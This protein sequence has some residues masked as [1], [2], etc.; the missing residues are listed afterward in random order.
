M[1]QSQTALQKL[2]HERMLDVANSAA[3]TMDGDYFR[4]YDGTDTESEKYKETLNN[5]HVFSDNM[6]LNYIYSIRMN[7][8]GRFVFVIDPDPVKPGLYGE[9][10]VQTE[11]QMQA[12]T[13]KT[14]TVDQEAFLDRWGK[15]YSAYS[16]VFDGEGN[17][18]ALIAVDFDA[19]W[20]DRQLRN[21]L[22]AILIGS[23]FSLFIG[24]I[25]SVLVTTNIR[26]R[27]RTVDGELNEVTD[28]LTELSTEIGVVAEDEL[29]KEE[30][31]AEPTG[32]KL[33]NYD[34]ELYRLGEKLDF[35]HSSIRTYITQT[36][37]MAYV[38][39]M[40]KVAN[41]TAYLE[42]ARKI[43]QDVSCGNADFMIA[44]TDINGL[45]NVNDNYGHAY[46]DRIITD[47]A[48]LLREIFGEGQ[49]FR[50]GG[51]EFISVM[52]FSD[53]ALM[54][55]AFFALDE[56]IE[57]FNKNERNYEP[58]LS[59]AKGYAVF[60]PESDTS[61]RAVFKRA[62]DAMYEDKARYYMSHGD[63]RRRR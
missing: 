53:E 8:N 25:F 62:D 60:D 56:R 10:I 19:N 39:G 55:D 29:E 45:K 28:A 43:E 44:V 36:H 2:I 3:A 59:L 11:G 23:A 26:S 33:L 35:L 20:Y 63:R 6:Q 30:F 17:I 7:E 37:S 4:D 27:F 12:W 1:Q 54:Q 57:D 40:T 47:A 51:D 9:E 31:S 14:A 18:A 50:I 21:F 32:I 13:T 61:F 34:E 15:F 5:F 46:G 38:D 58:L 48:K 22:I 49:V 52:M 16:P 24:I 42:L 41:K